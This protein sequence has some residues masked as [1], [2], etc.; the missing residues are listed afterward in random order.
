MPNERVF[1]LYL[2]V[3]LVLANNNQQ[4]MKKYITLLTF[5]CLLCFGLQTTTAQ[6]ITPEISAKKKTME[7]AKMT[8]LS[9]EQL[10]SVYKIYLSY[11]TANN[12]GEGMSL[13]VLKKEIDGVLDAEQ[14]QAAAQMYNIERQVRRKEATA[15]A[16]SR[17]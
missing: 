11:E 9:K 7:L 14:R 1:M 10:K 8:N 4:I 17:N 12:N 6:E 5:A 15:K 13:A 16:G 2:N 3:K